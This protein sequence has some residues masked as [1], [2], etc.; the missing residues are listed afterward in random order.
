MDARARVYD[1]I[2]RDHL[3]RHRQMAFVSGPR[4]VG[5]TTTCR[6][7]GT[8]YLNWDSVNDRRVILRG[9]DAV[10]QHVGLEHLREQPSVL[11]LDE[12]HKDRK[13]KNFLKG[14]FDVYGARTR[15][16]VTGSS[17]LD[18]RRRGSDSLMGRYFC[19]RMH[20][21]SVGECARINIPDS[22]VRPPQ[23]IPDSDWGALL[24]HGGFPEPFLLRDLRFTRRWRALRQDQLTKEDLREVAQLQDLGAMEAFTVLLAEHSAQ[25]LVYSNL[26]REVG[27]A[28]DTARRWVDLLVRLHYGFIVR[29]WFKNVAKSLRKEPKWF[30]RD[31]S[32]IEDVG[33][34]AETLIA[35]HLLKAVEGWTDLGLG[36]FE[37]RYLRDKLKREVDFLV[38][39]DRK[40]W[41][42]VEV[43]NGNDRLSDALR[44][45]QEQIGAKHAFQVALE[46]P[47]EKADCFERTDPVI[48]PA[49]TFLSQLL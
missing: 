6:G 46:K 22:P 11:V 49:R 33:A 32:G 20:P 38:V 37:L 39:R 21:W 26:S 29:P 15:V 40:P 24:E 47:F 23:P 41:F 43:K 2:L 13:W 25:Q 5:K 8:S 36:Q 9:P 35:C 12:L 31:W 42:V 16:I 28:V 34:R 27:I 19:F 45:F 18:I 10:A 30:L 1:H 17:R 3:A 4:Q 48:V 14:F 44:Y 7:I